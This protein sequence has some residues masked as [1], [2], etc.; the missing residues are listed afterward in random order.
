VVALNPLQVRAARF[1]DCYHFRCADQLRWSTASLS[2]ESTLS[3][4]WVWKST[5]RCFV[6]S[7]ILFPSRATNSDQAARAISYCASLAAVVGLRGLRPSPVALSIPDLSRPSNLQHPHQQRSSTTRGLV[8]EMARSCTSR[9][10]NLT[11]TSY[12]DIVDVGEART[13]D[14]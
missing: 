8:V 5:V 14:P 12:N 4:I 2:T 1:D 6:V 9:P 7:P 3:T 10:N 13:T 11:V